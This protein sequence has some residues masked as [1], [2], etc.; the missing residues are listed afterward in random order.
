MSNPLVSVIIPAYNVEKVI[1]DALD[2]VYAQTYRPIEIIVIDDGSTDRTADIVRNYIASETNK[3]NRTDIKLIYVYQ[4]NYGPSKARNAGIKA[5]KG[6]Y[7][8]FLDADDLWMQDKVEKQMQIF[9]LEPDVDIVSSD[10][11][12]V[13][14]KNG[15]IQEFLYYKKKGLDEGFFGHKFLVLEPFKKLLKINFM[16]TP[17]AI[18]KKSCFK[19]GFFFNEKRHY[20]EDWEL[21]LI[22]SLYYKFAY[23]NEACVHV[24]S[25]DDGL[26][27]NEQEMFISTI[28]IVE[29][30]MRERSEKLAELQITDKFL[31]AHL[32]DSFKW[33]G[34]YLMQN[35]NNK[36]ARVYYKKSLKEAFDLKTTFYYFLSFL[37]II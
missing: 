2:S 37:K 26:S 28:E 22:M 34:Y 4:K 6:E 33:M 25:M 13:Q 8:A 1:V 17:S 3:T 10:V 16:L 7:I 23:V 9:T 30:F 36:L 31:S 27:S 14:L 19:E 18:I 12:M 15:K 29:S 21:W 5:S 24:R 11:K 35:K 20:A 32:K